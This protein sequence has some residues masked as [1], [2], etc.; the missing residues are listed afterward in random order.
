VPTPV[1]GALYSSL[2]V[3]E[4]LARSETELPI[5]PLLEGQKVLGTICNHRGQQLPVTATKEQK[6]AEDY[7]RPE[8]YVCPMSSCILTGGQVEVPTGIQMMWEV[9]LG[10]VIS[11]ACQGVPVD[12]A[13]DYVG[14]YVVVL[15][16]TGKN[17]GFESMKHGLS[18]TLNKCQASF[19]PMGRF[20]KASEIQ[21]PNSLTLVCKVNGSEVARDSTAT[22]KFNIAE[23]VADASR[24]MPLQRGDV[25]LAGAGSMGDLAIGDIVEGIVEGLPPVLSVSA[26]LA[27]AKS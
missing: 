26:T 18:W 8:W 5:Y 6:K 22:L 24:L 19:K 13:M 21:D 7:K 17:L 12:K 14:G 25:L 4:R 2:L 16:M 27:A 3:R 9:E 10:V 15:D 11:K 23:Q 1:V 20:I